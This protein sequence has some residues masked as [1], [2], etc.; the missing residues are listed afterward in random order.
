M[1]NRRFERW[2]QMTGLSRVELATMVDDVA[3]RDTPGTDTV[4]GASAAEQWLCGRSTSPTVPPLLL[5]VLNEYA[6][7]VLWEASEGMRG[8]AKLRQITDTLIESATEDHPNGRSPANARLTD[9]EGEILFLIGAALSNRQIAGRLQISEKTVKNHITS[10]FA[11]LGVSA[12]SEAI[13][14]A[15]RTGASTTGHDYETTNLGVRWA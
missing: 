3:R 13:V 14:V 10:L 11:K 6:Q 7:T 4:D 2:L 8:A 12:R 5:D 9:R 1:F 15:L